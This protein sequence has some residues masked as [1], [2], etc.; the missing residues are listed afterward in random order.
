[1]PG[2]QRVDERR[3]VAVSKA[4]SRRRQRVVVA[5]EIVEIVSCVYHV[6]C[7]WQYDGHG[8]LSLFV[9]HATHQPS[10]S[11]SE[12]HPNKS[13][14]RR[15]ANLEKPRQ[16]DDVHNQ[17]PRNLF[18]QNVF[19]S[20][21]QWSHKG[22]HLRAKTRKTR[23]RSTLN[24]AL[25][26][27]VQVPDVKMVVFR[28]TRR[29]EKRIYI[30]PVIHAMQKKNRSHMTSVRYSSSSIPK[31]ANQT[32]THLKAGFQISMGRCITKSAMITKHTSVHN[33]SPKPQKCNNQH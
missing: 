12:L 19:Y 27:K 14:T 26:R 7:L 32:P 20:H 13:C 1:M 2:Q 23:R 33:C 21:N 3:P 11:A 16:H 9:A 31:I 29:V 22:K 30:Q 18:R 15:I 6:E 5:P 10:D 4:L 8:T 24:K 28:R 25:N 17:E